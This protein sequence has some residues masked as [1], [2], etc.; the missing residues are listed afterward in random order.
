MPE[1][2]Q[3]KIRIDEDLYIVDA[4][5]DG[6][7]RPE[8]EMI[9]S[10]DMVQAHKGEDH[11]EDGRGNRITRFNN[12]VPYR[13]AGSTNDVYRAVYHF[14][15]SED[16]AAEAREALLC[17]PAGSG[18][19]FMNSGEVYLY[20]AELRK[21]SLDTALA[22]LMELAEMTAD[23]EAVEPGDFYEAAIISINHL[24]FEN[25]GDVKTL[26]AIFNKVAGVQYDANGKPFTP[27]GDSHATITFLEREVEIARGVQLYAA[28]QVANSIGRPECTLTTMRRGEYKL[29]D[30]YCDGFPILDDLVKIALSE[31]CNVVVRCYAL[32]MLDEVGSHLSPD[33]WKNVQSRLASLLTSED[34]YIRESADYVI[35]GRVGRLPMNM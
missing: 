32:R 13:F 17:R 26:F 23:C 27:I 8:W 22:G 3:T 11:F 25:R 34:E 19:A 15:M 20:A 21:Q 18:I 12:Y 1:I 33:I 5:G 10:N 31:R 9:L 7:F 35:N 6:Y 4:N 24:A 29:H 28:G 2:K 14:S 30:D 16:A